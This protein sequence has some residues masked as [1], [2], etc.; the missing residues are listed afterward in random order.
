MPNINAK[1]VSV[2]MRNALNLGQ[3]SKAKHVVTTELVI[4]CGTLAGGAMRWVK[5]FTRKRLV[6]L[7]GGR[8]WAN[9]W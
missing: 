4:D 6:R 5:R 2:Q 9:I 8:Q 7:E 3:E 1:L